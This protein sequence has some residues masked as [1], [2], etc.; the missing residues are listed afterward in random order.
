MK[1][2]GGTLNWL[3]TIGNAE[4]AGLAA[5]FEV[6]LTPPSGVIVAGLLPLNGEDMLLAESWG[7][8]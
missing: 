5:W 4:T 7:E 3:T 8:K 2:G 6:S 1:P